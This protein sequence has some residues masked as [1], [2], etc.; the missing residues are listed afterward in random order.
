M[1]TAKTK[2]KIIANAKR[3]NAFELE[4]K[5]FPLTFIKIVLQPSYK[6]IIHFKI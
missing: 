1:F 2:N 3:D 5:I 6:N 4:L